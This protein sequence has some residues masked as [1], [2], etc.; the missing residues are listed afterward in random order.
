MSTNMM[1][2]QGNT[3][4]KSTLLFLFL[5]LALPALLLGCKQPNRPGFASSSVVPEIPAPGLA[6]IYFYRNY[7][8]F[9]RM[10]VPMQVHSGEAIIGTVLPGTFFAVD[11]QPGVHH[12]W[13][14]RQEKGYVEIEMNPG[15]IFF[16]RLST[17]QGIFVPQPE[18]N[19]TMPEMAMNRVKA[20]QKFESQ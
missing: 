3:M 4:R 18:M 17:R 12:F 6:K 1:N 9:A 5:A 2:Y 8:P 16:V 13:A 10:Q 20:M 7:E 15:D 19:L 14:A 11:V